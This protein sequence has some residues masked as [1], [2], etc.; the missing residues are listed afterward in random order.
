MFLNQH[1]DYA[2]WTPPV[3]IFTDS[4]NQYWIEASSIPRIDTTVEQTNNIKNKL[5]FITTVGSG[6]LKLAIDTQAKA[7]MLPIP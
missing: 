1:I 6:Q 5:L 4:S 3:G 7:V 2:D